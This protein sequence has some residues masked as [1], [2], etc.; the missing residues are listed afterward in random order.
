MSQTKFASAKWVL[1]RATMDTLQNRN[2]AL[3][4]MKE[5]SL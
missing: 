1:E 5:P 4:A 3:W 2:L